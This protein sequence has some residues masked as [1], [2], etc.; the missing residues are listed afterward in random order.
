MHYK[1]YRLNR[2]GMTSI[3]INEDVHIIHWDDNRCGY[4]VI[5][6]KPGNWFTCVHRDY[7]TYLE[8]LVS[9]L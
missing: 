4:R 1:T 6:R 3:D 9:V 8:A 2:V 7:D 5:R